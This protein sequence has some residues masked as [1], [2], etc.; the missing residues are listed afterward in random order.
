MSTLGQAASAAMNQK[1]YNAFG[2]VHVARCWTAAVV[3]ATR[4]AIASIPAVDVG[5]GPRG[6]RITPN[7]VRAQDIPYTGTQSAAPDHVVA[8]HPEG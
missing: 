7:C 3:L 4:T 5:R 8:P 6:L 1:V 2:I